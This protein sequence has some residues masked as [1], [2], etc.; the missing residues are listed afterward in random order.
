MEAG[1][2]VACL[3]LGTAGVVGLMWLFVKMTA[4]QPPSAPQLIVSQYRGNCPACLRVI[5]PGMNIWWVR[6]Q[7]ARHQ[8]CAIARAAEEALGK[9]TEQPRRE[10]LLIEAARIG[11]QAT[12][13][14]VDTL[15]GVRAKRRLLEEALVT[16][17]A[18]PVP[19]E[20]QVEEVAWLSDALKQLD[21]S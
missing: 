6:G 1:A 7:K 5:L 2:G 3:F 21:E 12:L 9:I 15:K 4:N 19:D 11:V 10:K 18:D 20:L 14:K 16:L 8:D 17:R 13:D